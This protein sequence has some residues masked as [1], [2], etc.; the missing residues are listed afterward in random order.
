MYADIGPLSIKR[1]PCVSTIINEDDQ[2]V[3]YSLLNFNIHKN[4]PTASEKLMGDVIEKQSS[5]VYI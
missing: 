5:G 2:R 1:Q 3:E 4:K